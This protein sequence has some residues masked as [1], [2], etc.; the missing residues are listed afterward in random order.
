MASELYAARSDFANFGSSLASI[1]QNAM[2]DQISNNAA[3]QNYSNVSAQLKASIPSSFGD[4]AF[5]AYE[6]LGQGKDLIS[7]F[8][9]VKDAVAAAPDALKAALVKGGNKLGARVEQAKTLAT[10]TGAELQSTAG[11]LASKATDIT[12]RGV[13]T[14]TGAVSEVKAAAT[15]AASEVQAAATG[16]ASE[17]QAAAEGGAR[18]VQAA[19]AGAEIP[20]FKLPE[21][22][23]KPTSF[24]LA[25]TTQPENI[26]QQAIRLIDP[27]QAEIAASAYL[28]PSEGIANLQAE[29]GAALTNVLGSSQEAV[30]RVAAAGQETAANLVGAGQKAASTVATTLESTVAKGGA[31]ANEAVTAGAQAGSKVASTLQGAGGAAVDIAKGAAAD[32]AETAVEASATL[33]PVIGE[34]AAVALG[35]V[36]LYEGFKDLFDHPSA[37]KPVT[38]PLPSVASIAQGFQSG[39]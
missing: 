39:I 3:L 26:R 34:V 33:L 1:Q 38:V 6:L 18:E 15:G 31:L 36:Q 5:G 24:G 7:R 20:K 30:T 14:A 23:K 16:A 12:Q 25:D 19:A 2:D 17:V 21:N 4:I 10:E 8:S 32:V 11:E 13:T 28:K 9:K 22:V 27:E 35:G 29:G 37:A